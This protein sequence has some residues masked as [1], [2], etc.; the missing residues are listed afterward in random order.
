MPATALY[1]SAGSRAASCKRSCAC[2]F[3][4]GAVPAQK[5]PV[6]ARASYHSNW[7]SS[8][9][10]NGNGNGAALATA[11]VP[12]QI[13]NATRP[14]PVTPVQRPTPENLT[15]RYAAVLKHF[16]NALGVDDFIAR[17][18]VALCY[19]GFTGDNTIGAPPATACVVCQLPGCCSTACAACRGLAAR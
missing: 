13:Q 2:G 15:E 19:F 3:C 14:L 4:R 5:R 11:T 18:E 7:R 10:G 17:V 12:R 6:A 8:S 9:N 16:P 1:S